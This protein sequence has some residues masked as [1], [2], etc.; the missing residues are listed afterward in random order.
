MRYIFAGSLEFL[1][2]D[3]IFIYAGPCWSRLVH[4]IMCIK[5]Y[6]N[7]HINVFEWLMLQSQQAENRN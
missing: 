1:I 7:L 5:V 6:I 4:D 3:P 2:D